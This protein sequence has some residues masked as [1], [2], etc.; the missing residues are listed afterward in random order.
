MSIAPGFASTLA[1][2]LTVAAAEKSQPL[3][4]IDWTVLVQFGIFLVM[5]LVLWALVF[6]PYLAVQEERGKR[7]DGAKT[8]A[9]AMQGRAASMMSD[10]EGQLVKAKQR[11]AVERLKLRAEGQAHEREVLGHARTVGQEALAAAKKDAAAQREAARVKLL[12]ESQA[13]G[14]RIASRILGRPIQ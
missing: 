1:S 8:D 7:I 10:Y 13:I 5:A 11:G 3:I 12:A 14:Q 2:G 6:K 9:A 4:D